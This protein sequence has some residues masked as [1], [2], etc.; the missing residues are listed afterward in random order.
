M[1]KKRARKPRTFT[2]AHRQRFVRAAE[3]YVQECFRR[4][5]VIQ[6]RGFARTIEVT[7]QYA[8]W[9]GSQLL[10]MT[11]LEWFQARQIEYAVKLLRRNVLEI[12]EIASLTGFGSI[13][14]FQRAF[15]KLT[16][17]TPSAFRT[18]KK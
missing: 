14:S 4:Q 8:S 3:H 2:F 10:G 12:H 16:G 9:L 7:P 5:V 13:R 15:R 17:L 11:L 6:T 18:L 1:T